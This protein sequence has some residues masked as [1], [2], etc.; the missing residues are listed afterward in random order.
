MTQKVRGFLANII[1]CCVYNKNA[2]RKLR[3]ILSSDVIGQLRFIRRDI[4]T[5]ITKVK[6]FVGYQGRNLIIAVNDKYIYKFPLRRPNATELTLREKRVVDVLGKCSPIPTPAVCILKYK[7]QLVRKYDFIHG[8]SLR[9]MPPEKILAHID[10]LAPKIA[11]FM[12]KIGQMNPPELQ[13][14][15]PADAGA[16]GYLYGWCQGDICDNFIMN[17]DTMEI[18]AFID[19]EDNF[20]GKF[21]RFFRNQKRTPGRELM[22]AVLVEY[23]KMFY[24]GK[25]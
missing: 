7:N 24:A 2:R 1:C 12:Y 8:C 14:L 21:D 25:K 9:Q 4:R 16:P 19:W 6:F 18:I 15:K 20:Y 11:E 5:R 22:A 3:A 23:D 10:T 13:D 17:P